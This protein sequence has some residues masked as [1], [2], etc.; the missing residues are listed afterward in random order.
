MTYTA[1][2]KGHPDAAELRKR[3]G[4]YEKRIRE[5]AKVT[6]AEL[7]KAVG[8][9]YYTFISQ[10]ESGKVRIPPDKY[11][12]WA[13]ALKVDQVEFVSRMMYYYDPYTWEALHPKEDPPVD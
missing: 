7:A 10:M 6:Q 9:T 11:I 1:P 4:A 3:A 2:L 13:R 5:K 8:L 12:L